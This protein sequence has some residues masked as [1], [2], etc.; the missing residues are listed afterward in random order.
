MTV[1]DSTMAIV[2]PHP[3]FVFSCQ[4][5]LR[6]FVPRLRP[7]FEVLFNILVRAK[8]QQLPAFLPADNQTHFTVI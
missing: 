2:H 3:V 1:D 7:S 5:S 4:L 6:L 8:C